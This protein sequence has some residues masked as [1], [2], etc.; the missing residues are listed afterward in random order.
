[1]TIGY[2][3]TNSKTD[4]KKSNKMKIN[5]K[6]TLKERGNIIEQ[7]SIEQEKERGVFNEQYFRFYFKKLYLKNIF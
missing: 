1:M 3:H 5:K 4:N 6:N 7:F 2:W